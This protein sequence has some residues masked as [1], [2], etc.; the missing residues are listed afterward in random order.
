MIVAEWKCQ[1][2]GM[3]VLVVADVVSALNAKQTNPTDRF[4]TVEPFS[5]SFQRIIL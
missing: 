4:N 2:L 5:G 1:S 3:P